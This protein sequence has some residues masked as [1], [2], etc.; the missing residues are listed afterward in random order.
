MSTST[1]RPLGDENRHYWLAVSM[2]KATGTDL[3]SALDEGRISHA[4]WA[5]LVTRCRSCQWVE[6]C[7][8]WL[9]KQEAGSADPPDPCVNSAFFAQARDGQDMP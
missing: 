9:A 6:G 5:D 1:P 3:Q 2:A 8:C 7:D 4:D